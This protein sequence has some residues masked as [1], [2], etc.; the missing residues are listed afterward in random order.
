MS[1]PV[2]GSAPRT[3]LGPIAR[4][5]GECLGNRWKM[6][7][8]LG[9]A[10]LFVPRVV[11]V[12][13]FSRGAA[14]YSEFIRGGALASGNLLM[15]LNEL[16]GER[17]QSGMIISGLAFLLVL[18]GS[19]AV[20]KACND[21][22][23]EKP[24][25]MASAFI[26][27]AKTLATKGFGA[28]FMLLLILIPAS[29]MTLLRVIVLCLL[30]VLPLELVAGR[31]GGVLSVIDVL[32]LSYVTAPGKSKWPFFSNIMTLGGLAMSFMFL[33]QMAL[34]LGVDLDLSG[35]AGFAWLSRPL[36]FYGAEMSLGFLMAHLTE[37]FF[38]TVL[39]TCVMPFAA[40]LRHT[41]RESKVY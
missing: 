8:S 38:D 33:V 10:L 16:A 23:D 15:S 35:S 1:T 40:A 30:I 32:R 19:L 37:I 13:F 7:L 26:T 29:I 39:I 18:L 4:Y 3:N 28:S 11:A 22:F 6:L 25:N 9:F 21:Y 31:R 2:G 17:L 36:N 20:A 5:G 12:F 24:A 27:G 14:S 34:A 41:A